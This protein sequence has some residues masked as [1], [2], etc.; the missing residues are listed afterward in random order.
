VRPI[1]SANQLRLLTAGKTALAVVI[2]MG[3]AMKLN[4]E[5]PYWT[6]VTAMIVSLP[7]VGAVFEKSAL[8]VL[9]TIFAG[10]L[11]F[12]LAG[13]F[14][15]NQLMMSV[16]LFVVL[17][18]A[19][20]GAMG[21][22]Y[23]YFFML[24]GITICIILGNV[25]TNPHEL[26]SLVLS[27]T[28]EVS[29][30]VV[31]AVAV[32][33]T[34]FPQHAAN[35]YRDKVSSLL[36]QC[37]SL[38]Q[39]AVDAY[40]HGKPLPEDIEDRERDIAAQFPA[41][42]A[43]LKTALRD[44]SRLLHHQRAAEEIMRET[45][46]C[47][48]AAVTSVRAAG[49]QRPKDLQSEARAE[50]TAY[51]KALR[52]DLQQLA[53]DLRND[54]PA[55]KLIASRNAREK[56]DARTLELRHTGVTRQYPLED[57][58]A[59]FAFIADLDAARE[60]LVRL[61]QAGRALY[62]DLESSE[63][64]PRVRWEPMSFKLDPARL[65]HGVK[66]AIASLT[67]LYVY[68]WLHWPAGVTAFLT[69]AI[70]M[71]MTVTAS[72]QKSLLRLGGCLMGGLFGAFTLGVIEPRLETYLAYAVPL[73][74][75]FFLFAWINVGPPKW[76]YAGFQAQLAFLL[77]TSISSQQ[78]LDLKAGVDRFMGILLGVFI[79][80]FV[81]RMIWPVLPEKEFRR[82]LATFFQRAAHFMREQDNRLTSQKMT[83]TGRAQEQDLAQIEYLP[84]KTLDWLGQIGFRSHEEDDQDAL[85]QTYLC[86]QSIAFAL[87]GMAQAN[88]RPIPA[89]VREKIRPEL[90]RMDQAIAAAFAR[91]ENAFT[92]G[93]GFSPGDE[94]HQAAIALERNLAELIRVQHATRTA[95]GQELGAFLALVRRYRELG[96]LA[97]AAERH[98]SGLNFNVLERSDFF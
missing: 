6:G 95:T 46:Q 14:E 77:M 89:G 75:I 1:L 57:A 62:R 49:S 98:V 52:A 8:R 10:F 41:L 5:R 21:K 30:G 93:E 7:Y 71:Q 94:I 72:N 65:R 58:A 12:V 83:P 37:G 20:Y 90:T 59:F 91:C 11:S 43:L 88:A 38:L 53:G 29:L 22:T 96:S 27:R 17:V 32:N 86:V 87:R 28:L 70:V 69:C 63:L 39:T 24:G 25:I 36:E 45:R 64:P 47:F 48:V 68:L 78:S 81:Q 80:G 61:A 60:A 85:T 82:E 3:I 50:L 56:L 33:A 42:V 4:W 73:Y 79:A 34:L 74:G 9:G 18:G 97:Q 13:W 55:R 66:V 26:W 44:S 15:Q 31:V 54:Q 2:A 76:A 19:G 51:C 40:V 92:R 67:A 16:S 35:Y 23:P 84:A